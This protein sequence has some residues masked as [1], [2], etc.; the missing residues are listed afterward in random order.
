MPIAK[1]SEPSNMSDFRPISVLPALSK[2]IEIIMKRQISAFLVKRGLLS[3]YQSGFR[4]TH[5]STLTALLKITN[6]FLI[7]TDE[8]FT[9]LNIFLNFVNLL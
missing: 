6:D 9:V 3:D 5:H 7:A 4:S 8:R 2:A 1:K